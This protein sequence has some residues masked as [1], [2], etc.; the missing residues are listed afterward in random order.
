MLSK[1]MLRDLFFL[2]LPFEINGKA[3]SINE[4]KDQKFQETS[5]LS[6]IYLTLLS[7]SLQYDF[8]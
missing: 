6:E 2:I 1:S 7:N 4:L 5:E 8:L 3:D